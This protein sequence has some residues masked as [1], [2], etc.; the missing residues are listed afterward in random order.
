MN[1][2]SIW[3]GASVGWLLAYIIR[4]ALTRQP[5]H[6]LTYIIHHGP[7]W[8]CLGIPLAVILV[9]YQKRIGEKKS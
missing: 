5:V 6:I 8:L 3:G 2:L 7:I 9:R 4:Q 1:A